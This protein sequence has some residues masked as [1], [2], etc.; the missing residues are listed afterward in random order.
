ML[1]IIFAVENKS[2]MMFVY[3]MDAVNKTGR[4]RLM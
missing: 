3:S 1:D 2:K 4:S